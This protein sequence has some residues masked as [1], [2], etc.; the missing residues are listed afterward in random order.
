MPTVVPTIVPTVALA[1]ATRLAKCL[2]LVTFC[3]IAECG[4]ARAQIA[5]TL[6]ISQDTTTVAL[7]QELPVIRFG[8]DKIVNTFLFRSDVLGTLPLPLG[9]LF[10]R[11]Q[12]RGSVIRLAAPAVR[13]DGDITLRYE[14]PLHPLWS[15]IVSGTA[16]V[17]ADTRA[18]GLN[19]LLQG[20]L[21]GG[22]MTRPM[23][24]LR[25]SL[26]AGGE[27]NEQLGIAD[28]GWHAQAQAALLNQRFDEYAVS[29]EVNAVYSALS[30]AR[31]NA[32]TLLRLAVARTFENGGIFDLSA[33]MSTLNRDFYTFLQS[34]PSGSG[35][36][37]LPSVET[38]REQLFRLQGRLLLPLV[39]SDWSCDAE[40]QGFFE[41]WTIGRW[42]RAPLERAALTAVDRTVDQAR[43]SVNASLRAVLS[44]SAHALTMIV[45]T[46]DETNVVSERFS[47]AQADLLSLRLSEQQRDN[48]SV[49]TSLLAQSL[50]NVGVVDT[51]KIEGSSSLLRYDTPSTL[52]NDDRDEL[53]LIGNATW[54]HAFSEFFSGSLTAEARFVHLV[55]LKSQRSAQNNW[56]RI[57]RLVPSFV[58]TSKHFV[59]R[60][61]FELL[62]N[63][64][65]FDFEDV[66]ASSQSFSFRQ[67]SYRDSLV[68]HCTP[69]TSV[70]SRTIF[71]YFER[72]EFRWR[73]FSEL[74][75]DRNYELFT[76]LL[77]FT[78]VSVGSSS[79]HSRQRSNEEHN[80][81]H[82]H[83][84]VEGSRL[85]SNN[86]S[87]GR[88]DVFAGRTEQQTF[89]LGIGA[90]FYALSQRPVNSSLPAAEFLNQIIGPEAVL[91]FPFL[92]GTM[93]RFNGWYEFQFDRSRLL[94]QIPNMM[95]S[96]I[97]VL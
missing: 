80:R 27:Y 87:I 69:R 33:Q 47:I 14:L 18:I 88:A 82:E 32:Q 55:F 83:N 10:M 68:W 54:G 30:N 91:E 71:R 8:I 46:R 85:L 56:N 95:L 58:Y 29:A 5:P 74:P 45:D 52:N 73:S 97:V 28:R 86:A 90:R 22:I 59:A 51:L 41:G 7:S 31:T 34:S 62:A 4:I 15:A 64:T 16:M 48:I 42:Y 9:K 53:T 63:Y 49:R 84:A 44:H 76:R 79:S 37:S 17:S 57:I 92:S 96:A 26:T 75:R 40:V 21:S 20:S 24:N 78:T 43:F 13:D 67:L 93:I 2:L 60:P 6:N 65:S 3:A 19:R 77:L 70:E 94:R 35:T 36:S 39:R 25:V 66:V 50:W 81:E 89:R 38:R 23:D 72:G 11:Q 12:Y 1:T 61:T